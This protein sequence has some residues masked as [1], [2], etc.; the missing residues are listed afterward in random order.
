MGQ[1]NSRI[2]QQCGTQIIDGGERQ[3]FCCNCMRIRKNAV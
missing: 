3:K 1:Q 2:C